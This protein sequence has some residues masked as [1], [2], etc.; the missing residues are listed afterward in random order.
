LSERIET[1]AAVVWIDDDGICHLDYR[2][3]PSETLEDSKEVFEAI[4]T[5]LGGARAPHLIDIRESRSISRES[6]SFYGSDLMKEV[7]TRGALLVKSGISRALGNFFLGVVG[8]ATPVRLFTSEPEA[9]DWLKEG[10]Q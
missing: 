8:P 10:D 6:R 2:G 7:V 1:R 4:K 5:L 3:V 9:L